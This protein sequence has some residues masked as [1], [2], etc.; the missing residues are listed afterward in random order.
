MACAYLLSRDTASH[1]PAPERS[2]SAKEWAEV[3]ADEFMDAMPDDT[4]TTRADS[5][6]PTSNDEKGIDPD[7]ARTEILDEENQVDSPRTMSVASPVTTADTTVP[8]DFHVQAT[9]TA[10]SKQPSKAPA[11]SEPPSALKEVLDLHTSRRMKTA[12]MKDSN[13]VKKGNE[14]PKIKQGVSI[15]SQRRWLLYW[16]LLL[17][18]ASPRGF[19]GLPG[20]ASS[21]QSQADGHPKA[22]ITSIVVRMREPRGVAASLARAF[23]TIAHQTGRGN[24]NAPKV[25][26]EEAWVSLARYDDRFVETLERWERHTRS[27]DGKLGVRAQGSGEMEG[28]ALA[29]MFESGKWDKDKVC[30]IV[31]CL[32]TLLIKIC[33]WF[34]VLRVWV[35]SRPSQ[36]KSLMI[37]RYP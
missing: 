21:P 34:A 32:S 27:A 17:S 19:W 13:H 1:K 25:T 11:L 22:F 18:G 29:E 15:P 26:G 6:E 5:P 12:S 4:D 16:S 28:E 36:L 9:E 7:I 30:F 2:L 8:H 37:Q 24:R 20:P 14:A 10:T 35:R 3:R 23:N 33:R 31:V